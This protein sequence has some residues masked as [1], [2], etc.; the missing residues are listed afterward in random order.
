MT[1][2]KTALGLIKIILFMLC[3]T[4]A[5]LLWRAL[6]MD[7]LGAKPLE[8]LTRATGEWTLRFLLV[9][10]AVTPLRKLSGWH[11]ILR[12]RRMLGLFTFAYG[13]VHLATYAWLDKRFDWHAIAGDLLERPFIAVGFA[14][15][16]LMTLLAATSSNFAIRK[17]GGRRWQS[18]HRAIYPIALLGCVHFWGMVKK[19]VTE[20]LIY[21]AIVIVLLGLRMGWREQERR[22]QL[23]G[24]YLPRPPALKGKVIKI[25]ESP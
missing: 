13:T 6:E 12:L 23:A 8:A 4:P 15:L 22:K 5:L 10:L 1:P 20:P 14:A 9:T 21:S 2:G 7:S 25:F 19:D 3:L 16:A 11:W 17:L 18:L 24:A